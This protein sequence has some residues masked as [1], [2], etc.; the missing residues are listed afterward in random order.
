MFWEL[1]AISKPKGYFRTFFSQEIM[2]P[3]R[4]H[5]RAAWSF[6]T[7][8]DFNQSQHIHDHAFNSQWS[9]QRS[10]DIL[11]IFNV[12]KYRILTPTQVRPRWKNVFWVSFWRSKS[13]NA[14]FF[15][16]FK[17]SKIW[18][19]KIWLPAWE[20]NFFKYS[21]LIGQQVNAWNKTF[22]LIT[23]GGID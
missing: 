6:P 7:L 18:K 16:K 10:M 4:V 3:L 19:F 11:N 17:I 22:F 2:R 1:A 21:I 5:E 23:L 20:L 13:W 8:L 14:Y 9:T 15:K 12:K